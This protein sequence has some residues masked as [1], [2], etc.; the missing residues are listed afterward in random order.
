MGAKNRSQIR[1]GQESGNKKTDQSSLE[2]GDVEWQSKS[3]IP[4]K[5]VEDFT[6]KTT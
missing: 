4:G 5:F 2:S 3:R 6:P 1:I